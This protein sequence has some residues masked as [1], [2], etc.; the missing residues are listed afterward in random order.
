M[1]IV[2]HPFFPISDVDIRQILD[3]RD[4]PILRRLSSEREKRDPKAGQS[5]IQRRI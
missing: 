2:V 1:M 3:N 5:V 4:L